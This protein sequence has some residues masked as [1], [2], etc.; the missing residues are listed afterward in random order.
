[1][2]PN[3]ITR[4]AICSAVRRSA[5]HGLGPCCER[6]R[7]WAATAA[8]VGPQRA[9]IFPA[10]GRPLRLWGNT[11]ALPPVVRTSCQ[12]PNA[13]RPVP[14]L[15]QQ[16]TSASRPQ[17]RSSSASVTWN[18]GRSQDLQTGRQRSP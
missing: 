11:Y 10:T 4:I 1:M 17:E 16:P 9:P 8:A 3:R 15:R 6:G 13:S 12:H 14:L 5:A 18:T 2:M 7:Y